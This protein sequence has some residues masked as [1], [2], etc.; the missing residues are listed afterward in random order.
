M[1]SINPKTF[2]RVILGIIALFII[3]CL[4]SCVNQ[5]SVA[6]WIDKNGGLVTIDSTHYIDSIEFI[7]QR[8]EVDT[9][10]SIHR[11]DTMIIRKDNLT[12]KTFV[13]KDSIYVYGEVE[14]DTVIKIV[15]RWIPNQLSIDKPAERFRLMDWVHLIVAAFILLLLINLLRRK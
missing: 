15:D 14:A 12:I 5:R 9:V 2:S 7:T 3:I 10:F 4:A 1:I 8:T 13:Y 6:R 11:T